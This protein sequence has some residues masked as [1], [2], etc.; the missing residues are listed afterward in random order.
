MSKLGR[1]GQKPHAPINLLADFAGGG[2][3]CALAIVSALYQRQKQEHHPHSP[4]QR[5]IDCS[6]VEGSAYVASW[7]WT[8]RDIDG[9]WSSRGERGTSMLDGG[10]ACYDTYETKDGKH[11]ACGALE[12]QFRDQL[13]KGL[14]VDMAGDGDVEISS[15]LLAT[16]FKTKT[17]DEWA[18][19]FAEL[20]ACVSPVLDMDEAA[21]VDEHNRARKSF[22]TLDDGS[23]LPNTSWLDIQRDENEGEP[24]MFALPQPG[25]NTRAILAELG[26]DNKHIEQLVNDGVVEEDELSHPRS[27][28]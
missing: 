24:R 25:Q 6:M 19:V 3:M 1:K 15:E 2:L 11:V 28:L 8:S 9:L 20:D 4:S 14:G 13:L 5:V 10:Y 23:Y 12:P 16:K 17:R 26:F 27:K 18:L 7:L 21:V 22:V